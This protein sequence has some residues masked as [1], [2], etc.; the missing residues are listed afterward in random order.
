MYTRY[1]YVEAGRSLSLYDLSL[2][3]IPHSFPKPAD[4]YHNLRLVHA[5]MTGEPNTRRLMDLPWVQI[6]NPL[7]KCIFGL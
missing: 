6:L 1:C 7:D 2:K 4:S 5:I 3:A